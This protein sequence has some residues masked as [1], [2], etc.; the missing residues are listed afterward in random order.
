[1]A[2]EFRDLLTSLKHG[3]VVSCQAHFDHPLRSPRTMQ[4]LALC[5]ERG[6]AVGIRA[7]GPEDVASVKEGVKIPVIGIHKE[8]MNGRRFFITPTFAHAE[9]LTKAGA[10]VIA[11]EATRETR[12]DDGDLRGLIRRVREELRVPVM[13]DVSTLEEGVRAWG[14]G[15]DLVA[16]T[17]SGYTQESWGRP[18]PDLDLVEGLAK[19]QVRVACEGN[20]RTPE[21]AREALDRGAWSVV[22]GTA[23]TDPLAITSWF[24]DSVGTG[25]RESFPLY[26]GRDA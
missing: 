24:V 7:N 20:V 18:K 15:A 13:A 8:A 14:L 16:T 12:P 3:L 17:L 11:L 4:A 22:V 1:M 23:I 5:A 9:A 19:A 25:T 2:V 6:G 26:G 21:Q 10:D